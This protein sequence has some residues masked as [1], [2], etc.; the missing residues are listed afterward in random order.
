MY[1]FILSRVNYSHKSTDVLS[2]ITIIQ[3]TTTTYIK[4]KRTISFFHS[5]LLS[6]VHFPY[7][8]HVLFPNCLSMLCI[9]CISF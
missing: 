9:D 8:D 3:T 7:S 2:Y 4:E 1:Q 6:S 5:H